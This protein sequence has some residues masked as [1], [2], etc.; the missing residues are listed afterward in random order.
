MDGWGQC[1]LESSSQL[2]AE[3]IP[4]EEASF[5]PTHSARLFP[6]AAAK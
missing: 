3:V 6:L 1:T 2:P 5:R 4:S